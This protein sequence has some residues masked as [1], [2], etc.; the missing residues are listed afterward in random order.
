[1]RIG[2]YASFHIYIYSCLDFKLSA[3]IVFVTNSKS[4]SYHRGS[5]FQEIVTNKNTHISY[6]S[7][8]ADSIDF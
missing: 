1:M 7:Y 2:I 4:L 3:L 5:E 6:A 8:T